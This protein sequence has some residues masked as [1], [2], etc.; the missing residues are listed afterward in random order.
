[1]SERQRSQALKFAL[2]SASAVP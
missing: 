1:M 2:K